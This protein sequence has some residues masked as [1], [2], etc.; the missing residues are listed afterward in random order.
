MGEPICGV[1]HKTGTNWIATG[2][3][4]AHART[5]CCHYRVC[6]VLKAAQPKIIIWENPSWSIPQQA[7]PELYH[8]CDILCP[9]TAVWLEQ[10]KPFADFYDQ[11][12]RYGKELWLYSCGAATK[13]LDPYAYYLVQHWLCWKLAHKGRLSGRLVIRMAL[14][15]GTSMFR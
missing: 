12:R 5:G 3:R 15:P 14:L 7:D 9:Q 8:I 2:R 11:Q 4:I 13:L 10:G 6:Q 1:E